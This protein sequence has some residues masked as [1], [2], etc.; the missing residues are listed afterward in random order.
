VAYQGAYEDY[1]VGLAKSIAGIDL[2]LRFVGTRGYSVVAH[3]E[4]FSG[5]RR[6]IAS[7]SIDL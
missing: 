4:P 3:G 6:I 5:E 7:A 1:A 2:S